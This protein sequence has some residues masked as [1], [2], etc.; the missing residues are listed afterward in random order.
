[1]IATFIMLYPTANRRAFSGSNRAICSG[2]GMD[3]FRRSMTVSM[4][5]NS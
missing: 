5:V 1:M 4:A 2:G 3:V